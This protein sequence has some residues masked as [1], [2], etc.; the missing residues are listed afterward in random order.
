MRY[1]PTQGGQRR[2]AGVPASSTSPK[3][4]E[5]P[6]T[7]LRPPHSVQLDDIGGGLKLVE[8]SGEDAKDYGGDFN[9]LLS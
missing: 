2:P 3:L 6:H 8:L 4:A 7:R 5:A 1:M 9:R